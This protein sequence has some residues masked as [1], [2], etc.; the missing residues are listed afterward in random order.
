M[1]NN[2]YSKELESLFNAFYSRFLLRDFFGKIIPGLIFL[3][4]ISLTL[5][6]REDALW[7]YDYL[8]NVWIWIFYISISWFI[9]L[10]L[11]TFGTEFE[12]SLDKPR[13]IDRELRESIYDLYKQFADK[14]FEKHN[15]RYVVIKEAMGNCSISVFFSLILI[16]LN[17]IG[18]F[19]KDSIFSLYIQ[20][21]S[22]N[23]NVNFLIVC[24]IFL[25]FFIF[26][27]IKNREMTDM[28]WK[29]QLRTLYK[30]KINENNDLKLGE[31]VKVKIKSAENIKSRKI[32]KEI[33]ID[34][35]KNRKDNKIS[36]YLKNIK[37]KKK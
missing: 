8:K 23:S 16:I 6:S 28:Q 19:A 31:D 26:L 25:L 1:S 17:R 36:N 4:V 9:G 3:I 35:W 32:L 10:G 24:S 15:E 18:F 22:K 7:H 12:I 13:K 34:L 37:N 33:I 20:E 29:H 2:N 30:M 27:N 21:I 5:I 14:K 11:Q